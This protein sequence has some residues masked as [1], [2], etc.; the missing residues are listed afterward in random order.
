MG[1][2]FRLCGS[3]SPTANVRG[4]FAKTDFFGVA[5]WENFASA[6]ATIFWPAPKYGKNAF[7]RTFVPKQKYQKFSHSKEEMARHSFQP[8][9]KPHRVYADLS[10]SPWVAYS[11][12]LF[13]QAVIVVT[14]TKFSAKAIMDKAIVFLPHTRKHSLGLLT[15]TA[16]QIEN[17]KH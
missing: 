14:Q 6:E 17:V 2:E 11:S 16:V 13:V 5:L 15:M 10:S 12:Q 1:G 7:F 9:P 3:G 8:K 4:V